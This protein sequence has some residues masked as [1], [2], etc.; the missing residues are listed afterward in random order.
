[1]FEYCIF[2]EFLL[3]D[4]EYS[5]EEVGV[6]GF[7]LM[8]LKIGRV[9]FIGF[10]GIFGWDRYMV[11]GFINIVVFCKFERLEGYY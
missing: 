11:D 4:S 10:D 1:M 6:F 8:F 7:L 9:F 3:L 5:E 2:C